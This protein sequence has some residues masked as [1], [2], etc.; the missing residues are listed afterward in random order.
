M[1]ENGKIKLEITEGASIQEII[2]ILADVRADLI[3]FRKNIEIFNWKDVEEFL[4]HVK[5]EIN[6]IGCELSQNI[7]KKLKMGEFFQQLF[8]KSLK[9]LQEGLQ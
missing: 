8:E 6:Y 5:T 9:K 7:T 2:G 1:S 3:L 4:K